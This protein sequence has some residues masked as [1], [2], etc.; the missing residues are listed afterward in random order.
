MKNKLKFNLKKKFKYLFLSGPFIFTVGLVAGIVSGIWSIIPLSLVLTG[1]IFTIFW[2]GFLGNGFW[3][4]K[5]TRVGTNILISTLSILIILGLINFLASRYSFRIDFTENQ[6][7]TLSPKTQQIVKS[8]NQPLTVWVFDRNFNPVDREL[9]QNYGR[10]SPQFKF[11]FVDPQVEIGKLNAFQ[12]KDLSLGQ[13][14][15]EYGNKKQLVQQLYGQNPLNPGTKESISEVQLT[16][17]I[18]KI[19]RD[20]IPQIYFLT[21]HGETPLTATKDGLSQAV[22]NLN[23]KGYR[24]KTLN[25]VTNGKIPE[26]TSAI[27]LSNPQKA[28]SPAESNLLEKYLNNGGRLLL[29]LDPQLSADPTRILQSWGIK[30]DDRIIIDASGSNVFLGFGGDTTVIT[31]YGDRPIT[32]DFGEQNITLFYRARAVD[33]KSI[34]GIDAAPFLITD[35]QSWAESELSDRVNLDPIKD[36]EGP[37]NIGF[38]LTRSREKA[39]E[40]RLVIVGDSDFATNTWLG[41]QFNENLFI[42]AID[43]LASND[44]SA[45]SIEPKEPKN[46]RLNISPI[47]SIMINLLALFIV[48]L[49]GFAIAGLTWWKRR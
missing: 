23:A 24:V 2:L 33:I 46:R 4:Q 19:K 26:D 40:S 22:N 32:K 3:Q 39:K 41:Q 12:V 45:I 10:Y 13:V 38:S 5:S 34:A 43:W 27:V 48:P 29:M 8:L 9:L 30:L 18:A 49:L 47:Q 36:R 1:T 15:L 28:L 35:K 11:E 20:R 37:F 16:N 6:I 25:L 7:F 14:Y 17:A 44:D 21:G 31:Q 42:N